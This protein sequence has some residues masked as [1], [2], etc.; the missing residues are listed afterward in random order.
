MPNYSDSFRNVLTYTGQGYVFTPTYTRPRDPTPNDIRPKEQ[1]G[2]YVNC[3]LWINSNTF[4]IWIL[5]GIVNNLANWIQLS[6]SGGPTLQTLSDTVNAVVFPSSSASI[7][8]DNIQLIGVSGINV[9]AQPN[10]LLIG[11]QGSSTPQ[12]FNVGIRYTASTFTVL[13]SDGANLSATIPA[14]FTFASKLTPGLVKTATAT[15]NESFIDATGASQIV[16]NTFGLTSG[17]ANVQDIPFF[18]YAVTD[19]TETICTFMIS[20]FPGGNVSPVA[21]KIA[22]SGSA[23]AATQGSFFAL[24][25]TITVANFA[26]TPCTPIGSFRMRMSAANDWTV[27]TLV[28]TDGVGQFQQNMPFLLDTGGFG[29]AIGSYFIDNGGTAPIFSS[30]AVGYRISPDGYVYL[31]SGLSII[32]TP[33]LGAVTSQLASPYVI[34]QGDTNGSGYIFLGATTTFVPI[35]SWAFNNTN[36]LSAVGSNGFVQN[37]DFAANSTFTQTAYFK[38]SFI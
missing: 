28:S 26:S 6:A 12:A 23:V 2:K 36:M 8:P 32:T 29:A 7:P 19:T 27:Q 33:G 18:L 14:S 13:R 30:Q 21:G 1:Q 4:S 25:S 9:V 3:T 17:R 31:S 10:S 16:G 34:N 35:A 38:P 5:A 20:R 24:D 15:A 37:A 11:Q 22:K